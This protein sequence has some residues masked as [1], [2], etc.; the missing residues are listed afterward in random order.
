MMQEALVRVRKKMQK[1]KNWTMEGTISVDK[2]MA[3]LR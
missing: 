3:L 2:V 1:C